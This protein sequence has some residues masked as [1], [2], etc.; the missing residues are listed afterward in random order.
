MNSESSIATLSLTNFF[1]NLTGGGSKDI[2]LSATSPYTTSSPVNNSDLFKGNTF[3]YIL[4]A[5]FL[6]F[7]FVG[8]SRRRKVRKVRRSIRRSSIE[9]FSTPLSN[10]LSNPSLSPS[11]NPSLSPSSNPSLSPSSTP[12]SITSSRNESMESIEG[13]ENMSNLNPS[14]EF[15]Y[16]MRDSDK[17]FRDLKRVF[18]PETELSKNHMIRVIHKLRRTQLS[19]P[20]KIFIRRLRTHLS[21]NSPDIA[22][23]VYKYYSLIVIIV[24]KIIRANNINNLENMIKAINRVPTAK[25]EKIHIKKSQLIDIARHRIEHLK[26]NR[27]YHRLMQKLTTHAKFVSESHDL[28]VL[29][30]FLRDHANNVRELQRMHNYVKELKTDEFQK[31]FL[32]NI[33]ISKDDIKYIINSRITQR[34]DSK[35]EFL[36]KKLKVLVHMYKGTRINNIRLLFRQLKDRDV[37]LSKLSSILKDI[38]IMPSSIFENNLTNSINFSQ[39]SLLF[40]IAHKINRLKKLRRHSKNRSFSMSR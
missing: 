16:E 12:S 28:N 8:S 40:A 7:I 24:Q 39:R 29:V 10:P 32:D 19:R 27:A 23:N 1:S 38:D 33:S 9:D 2:N 21:E 3:K 35:S 30:D 25:L 13:M 4:I 5:I 22:N 34:E 37:K 14:E 15:L 6:Y 18:A 17:N 11:S 36:M 20:A 26:Q 31:K